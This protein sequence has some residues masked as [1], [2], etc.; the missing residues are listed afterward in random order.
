MS[1][2]ADR[3]LGALDPLDLG[4]QPPGEMVA[5]VRD[6]DQH[7]V[8]RA[9]V[10]LDD[11]VGDPGERAAHVLGVEELRSSYGNAPSG[12]RGGVWVARHLLLPSRP[13]GT[14][15]K[16]EEPLGS[17]I[18]AAPAAPLPWRFP[19]IKQEKGWIWLE[20]SS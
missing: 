7:D 4:G 20:K 17:S 16:G 9:L 15:L 8:R 1:S 12:M 5:A 18:H 11:L 10:P 6:P 2:D 3:H 19:I 13:R 14:G